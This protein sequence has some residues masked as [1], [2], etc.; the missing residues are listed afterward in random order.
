MFHEAAYQEHFV[1]TWQK[2]ARR[3]KGHRAVWGYDLINEPVQGAPPPEGVADYLGAQVKAARA[4]RAID[5]D[6][7]IIFAADDWDGP[8]GF[9]HPMPVDVPRVIYQVHMY[10]PHSFT[11]QGVHDSRTGV[12]YPGVIDGRPC[13]Q[14]AL[15]RYLRPVREFQLAYNVHIYCG[16]FSAIRWAPGAAGYLRDVIELFEE[17]GWDWSYHAYREWSGWS[18]EHSSD[19]K[20]NTPAGTATDRKQLLL[21]WFAKNHKPSSR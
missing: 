6:V 8:P 3:Y 7:P 15:R 19:S 13:D 2:I 20:D 9:K 14:D 21:R 5:R 11:H 4:I 16:E 1:K 18:V 17:Y 10:W 12:A